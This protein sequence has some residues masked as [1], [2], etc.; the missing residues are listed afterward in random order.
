[1]QFGYLPASDMETGALRTKE[2]MERAVSDFQRYADLP[3]TGQLDSE[4]MK[5]MAKPRCGVRDVRPEVEHDDHDGRRHR[6]YAL[7]PSKW[8]NKELTYRWVHFSLMTS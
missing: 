3:A 7:G 8:E 2:E 6:R 4:T 5:M 1:M